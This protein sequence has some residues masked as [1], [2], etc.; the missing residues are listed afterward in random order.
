MPILSLRRRNNVAA[1]AESINDPNPV[2]FCA[3]IPQNGTRIEISFDASAFN[4]PDD[5]GD[6]NAAT[7]IVTVVD[8]RQD[9]NVPNTL[10]KIRLIGCVLSPQVW[11]HVAVRM[12][13]SR[14]NRFSLS[15][16]F[17]SKDELSIFLNGKLVL[18]EAMKMPEFADA[19]SGGGVGSKIA[20]IGSGFSSFQKSNSS[21][22]NAQPLEMSFFSNIEGQ[23]GRCGSLLS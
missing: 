12:T 10:R 9:S 3:E 23:A 7:L 4:G 2:L 22:T 6:S 8:A 21:D 14:M 19:G 11:Y 16:P 15:A 20:R 5:S 18:K 13:R 17:T 1:A